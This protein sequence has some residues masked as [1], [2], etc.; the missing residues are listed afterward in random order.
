M[1]VSDWH[2]R[3]LWSPCGWLPAGEHPA[4]EAAGE[5]PTAK[6]HS[7][8]RRFPP[9]REL[10]LFGKIGLVTCCKNTAFCTRISKKGI[11]GGGISQRQDEQS[12]PTAGGRARLH[13]GP[14]A[15]SGP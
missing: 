13:G 15:G 6:G 8:V 9:L 14:S 1:R 5:F 3:T 12:H 2:A 4:A 7:L 10:I 11:V